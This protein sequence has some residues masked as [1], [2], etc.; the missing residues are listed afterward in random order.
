MIGLV[1]VL[2][3]IAITVAIWLYED[4]RSSDKRALSESQTRVIAQQ[5]R[6]AITDQGGIADAYA[7]DG[8]PADL[9]DLRAAKRDLHTSLGTLLGRG[10][11]D[12]AERV[13][14]LQV[15]A[16]QKRLDRIFTKQIV[17]VAGTAKFD[18]GVK[19][20][21]AVVKEV[22]NDLDSFIASDDAAATISSANE[23]ASE[24]RTASI[25]AT[26]L[27]ALA[28]LGVVLYARRL[29]NHLFGRLEAQFQEVDRQ[30]AQVELIR[31]SAETLREAAAEMASA[32]AEA[33][34]ATNQQ[35]A[36]V[37]EVA[38]T[39]DE[40]NATAAS[41]ADNAAAGTTAVEQTGDVMRTLQ[42]Q[43]QAI[44]ERSLTLGERSQ[45]I[46][47]V[48]EL[49]NEIAEQT[50]LLALNAAIEAARAGEAGKGFA[51]VASEVRKLAERSIRSTDEIREIITSVQDETNATIMATEQGTKQAREVGALMGS[52]AEVLEESVQATEQQKKAAGQVSTA[53][54]QVRTAAEQLAA[55]QEQRLASAQRVTGVVAELYEELE[56]LSRMAGKGS[57]RAVGNGEVPV[58]FDGRG[59]AA[60]SADGTGGQDREPAS[61]TR[62]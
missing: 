46:G 59:A 37:A 20:F 52:T 36:A 24:A 35:S 38:A 30:R 51:V 2:F 12:G 9:V 15:A 21:E 17:P 13:H 54:T 40:L 28:A 18:S 27:A 48:L 39:A 5:A 3:L 53:M 47:E 55:E 34:T 1:V 49:I 32:S 16:A 56:E 14:L 25:I 33:S 8:D 7:A 62:S 45:K 42:E 44:S 11:V 50:N 22:E 41:I 43:V 6:T 31:A 4:S 57:S 10:D 26:V 58:A 23:K 60:R 19:P 61:P 29:I